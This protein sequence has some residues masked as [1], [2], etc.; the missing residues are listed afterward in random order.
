MSINIYIY[1]KYIL[2]VDLY[3]TFMYSYVL[4]ADHL[5]LDN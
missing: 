3:A 2:T 1:F 4:S 5:V